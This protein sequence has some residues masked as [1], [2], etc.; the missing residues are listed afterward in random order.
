MSQQEQAKAAKAVA[1]PPSGSSTWVST[2]KGESTVIMRLLVVLTLL[3]LALSLSGCSVTSLLARPTLVG[4]TPTPVPTALPTAA[5]LNPAGVT[6]FDT[7]AGNCADAANEAIALIS[8]SAAGD[9]GGGSAFTMDMRLELT[10]GGSGSGCAD[11]PA[12]LSHYRQ[13]VVSTARLTVWPMDSVWLGA[14]P[15]IREQW[16]VDVLN[17]L[18]HLYTHAQ[19]TISV[20]S[21]NSGNACGSASLGAGSGGA[22]QVDATCYG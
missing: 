3:A 16:L 5:P 6:G 8:Q 2:P 1:F 4:P 18:N 10:P 9:F 22:R 21:T 15:T 12:R 20:I 7:G 14:G 17:A 11:P 19:I 13:Y